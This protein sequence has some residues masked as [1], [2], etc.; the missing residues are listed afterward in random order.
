MNLF[1]RNKE[2]YW[3]FRRY[4]RTEPNILDYESINDIPFPP[5]KYPEAWLIKQDFALHFIEPFTG[6][7]KAKEAIKV[8]KECQSWQEFIILKGVK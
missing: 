7:K 1:K 4:S 8:A 6:L 2:V 3:V 5:E